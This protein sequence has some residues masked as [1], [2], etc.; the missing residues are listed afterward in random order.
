MTPIWPNLTFAP[1]PSFCSIPQSTT[2]RIPVHTYIIHTYRVYDFSSI[3]IVYVVS[4]LSAWEKVMYVLTIYETNKW[5]FVYLKMSESLIVPY[6][7]V[8]CHW[9]SNLYKVWCFEYQKS[10]NSYYVIK[11]ISKELESDISTWLRI[12]TFGRYI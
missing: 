8:K 6:H 3:D 2:K 12:C 5:F 10:Y 4:L 7:N 9:S 11:I 1:I